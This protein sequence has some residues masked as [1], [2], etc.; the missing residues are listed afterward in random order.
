MTRNEAS[1][2]LG[3]SPL[4]TVEEA[5]SAYKKLAMQYHPDRNPDDKQADE[6]MK[7]INEAYSVLTNTNYN[8]Q[9]SF[10][11]PGVDLWE[12][13]FGPRTNP[14]ININFD[15]VFRDQDFNVKDD[16]DAEE[17]HCTCGGGL[18]I[19]VNSRNSRIKIT[20]QKCDKSYRVQST[21][22]MS[23]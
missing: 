5:K 16:M 8:P 23:Q 21:M 14:F 17:L 22:I 7:K 13:F 1:K 6:K 12:Q 15:S 18:K 19:A 11:S 3:V 9:Q 2:I 20:C 10:R 4:A